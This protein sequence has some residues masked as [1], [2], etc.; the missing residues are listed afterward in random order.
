MKSRKPYIHT[1]YMT[2]SVYLHFRYLS[3]M[4]GEMRLGLG[5][6]VSASFSALG[7]DGIFTDRDGMGP[8]EIYEF[9]RVH[10]FDFQGLS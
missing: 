4:F 2:V 1:A 7:L 10:G 9:P 8:L 6:M 3:E 5:F